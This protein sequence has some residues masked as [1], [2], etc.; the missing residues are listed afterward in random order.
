MQAKYEYVLACINMMI[1]TFDA[2]VKILRHTSGWFGL[3]IEVTVFPPCTVLEA[4]AVGHG[5]TKS[6]TVG[7][8]GNTKSSKSIPRDISSNMD[9]RSR[10]GSARL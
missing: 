9:V 1:V 2:E 5:V 4:A 6:G 8:V 3:R 7:D 10:T